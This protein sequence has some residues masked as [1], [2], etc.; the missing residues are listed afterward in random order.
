MKTRTFATC[1]GVLTACFAIS[2]RVLAEDDCSGHNIQFGNVGVLI[3]SDPSLPSHLAVGR[4]TLTGPTSSQ[5]SYVDKDGDYWTVVNDWRSGEL[6]GTWYK[7]SGTGKWE[8]VKRSG[9][10]KQVRNEGDVVI[11]AWGGNCTWPAAGK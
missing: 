1:L 8:N 2:S 4:S 9:W 7:I 6:Q 3:E 10:W 5:T 11:S